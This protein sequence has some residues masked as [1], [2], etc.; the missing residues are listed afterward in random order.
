[1]I[2]DNGLN[3]EKFISI[4]EFKRSLNL[5]EMSDE[6]LRT[7]GRIIQHLPGKDS[8]HYINDDMRIVRIEKVDLNDPVIDLSHFTEYKE[9]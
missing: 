6:M 2:D 7:V 1:M 9:D 4:S 8:S 3:F 5:S